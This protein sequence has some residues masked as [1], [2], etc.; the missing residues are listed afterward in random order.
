[1][2]ACE[3]T[4]AAIASAWALDEVD[5]AQLAHA[6]R[7]AGCGEVLA[8]HRALADATA[9]VRRSL[10]DVTLAPSSWVRIRQGVDAASARRGAWLR[11]WAPAAAVVAAVAVAVSVWPAPPAQDDEPR[12]GARA[13][14][15]VDGGWPSAP[16][17]EVEP[18]APS[19][20]VVDG[21]ARTV[22]E[23][24]LLAAGESAMRVTAFG[25]HAV[26]I[27]G[28]AVALVRAWDPRHVELE[29]LAGE[30]TSEV[31]RA[32]EDERFA[33]VSGDVTVRVLGTVFS[34][35]RE[36]GATAVEVARGRVAV[37]GPAGTRELV[38]GE[39][40]VF[41]DADAAATADVGGEPVDV[42]A[43]D[44]PPAR[45]ARRDRPRIIEIDV[46]AQAMP[47]EGPAEAA[48]S[49]ERALESITE[50]I[51]AGRCEAAMNAL[52]TLLEGA[53]SEGLAP[54]AARLRARCD[55]R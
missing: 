8:R 26:T 45:R 52:A 20:A 7:C 49:V 10:E 29:V 50:A 25:R 17:F 5:G 48:W 36:D 30:V 41:R 11:A 51:D 15:Q 27:A 19:A 43:L 33:V 55:A 31:K 40:D 44:E 18:L 6:E 3:E 38:A 53:P 42:G 35:A 2:S 9:R 4:R 47:A 54:R 14:A 32:H 22:A 37:D 24:D 23:G 16:R 1:M 12:P 46:P 28:G 13:L 34:V 39:A 21:V